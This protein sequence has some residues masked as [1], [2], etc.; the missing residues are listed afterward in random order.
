MELQI[1]TLTERPVLTEA[2]GQL[3]ASWPAFMT[4]D[5]VAHAYWGQLASTFPDYTLAAT[6]DGTVVARAYSVPFALRADGRGE[7]PPDGWDRV[8][9]WAFADHRRGADTDT[10]SALEINIDPAYQGRGWSSAMLGAMR[11]N[12]AAR[13]FTELVAPVRPNAKHHEPATPMSEY[14]FRVR[15]DGLPYDPWL[16]VHVRAG[17]RIAAVAPTSMTIAGS[18]TEWRTWTGK[19]FDTDGPTEVDGALVP[20]ECRVSHNYAVYVEPNV[21]VRHPL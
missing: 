2:I 8:L 11:A 21:W 6:L 10:V 14:A 1:T 3:G 5:I 13:G 4:E 18:L 15:D 9:V 12:A 17:A 20:V 7:L 19:P 16:R